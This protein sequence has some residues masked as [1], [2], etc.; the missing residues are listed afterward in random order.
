M[1]AISLTQPWASMIAS[2]Q[3]TIETRTWSTNYRGDLL[4]CSSKKPRIEPAGF[5]LC[6]VE[7]YDCRLMRIEDQE[8]ACCSI[9]QG[10]YSWFLRNIRKLL[11]P[12]PVKGAL[13]IYEVDIS[14][15][16]IRYELK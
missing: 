16:D 12:F 4:I 6:I 11:N 15:C 2:S 1:K 14:D 8:S 13:S 9:Y 5:A 3:K 7:L 10:A